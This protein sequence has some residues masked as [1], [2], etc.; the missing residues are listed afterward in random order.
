MSR[1]YAEGPRPEGVT[2]LQNNRKQGLKQKILRV[3]K[4]SVIFKLATVISK[5]KRVATNMYLGSFR[6][7]QIT[8]QE[9]QAN[10]NKTD[11]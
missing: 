2:G 10:V 3:S 4:Q 8:C 7:Q 5:Q 6:E 11:H 9:Q 1:Q